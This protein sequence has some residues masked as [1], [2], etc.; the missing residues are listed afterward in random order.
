MLLSLLQFCAAAHTLQLLQFKVGP[1][2]VAWFRGRSACYLRSTAW[3]VTNLDF[4]FFV[5]CKHLSGS[6]KHWKFCSVTKISYCCSIWFYEIQ[7]SRKRWLA[8][9]QLLVNTVFSVSSRK[10][11]SSPVVFTSNGK[12]KWEMDTQIGEASAVM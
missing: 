6:V 11:L 8:L 2:Y 10:V 3:L 9:S 4:F 5:T 12:I 7:S 1:N